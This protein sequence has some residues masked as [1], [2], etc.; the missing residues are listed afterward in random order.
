MRVTIQSRAFV[1]S[2]SIVQVIFFQFS[3]DLVHSLTWPNT[4]YDLCTT[5]ISGGA[6]Q[7]HNPFD[8][9]FDIDEPGRVI[10]HTV[11]SGDGERETARGPARRTSA[12]AQPAAAT[13]PIHNANCDLC[14]SIIQGDRYVCSLH[15]PQ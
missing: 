6:A 1:T 10:V 11:F 9:F 15:K 5:C 2:V 4:D 8:E 13:E 3:M 14:D 7:A 12:P